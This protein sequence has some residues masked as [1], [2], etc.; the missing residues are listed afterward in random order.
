MELLERKFREKK[1]KN[2]GK[3]LK[4]EIWALKKILKDK[5]MWSQNKIF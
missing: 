1:N 3:L 4:N 5:K 2:F